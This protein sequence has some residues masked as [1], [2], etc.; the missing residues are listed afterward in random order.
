MISAGPPHFTRIVVLLCV[1][2]SLAAA[3]LRKP[4]DAEQWGLALAPRASGPEPIAVRLR[5]R[6][7]ADMPAAAT[8]QR[9]ALGFKF[10]GCHNSSRRNPIKWIISAARAHELGGRYARTSGTEAPPFFTEG[11]C[12]SIAAK[13]V[14]IMRQGR[15]RCQ[16]KS[17]RLR[18]RRSP[19]T[20]Q[21]F[22]ARSSGTRSSATS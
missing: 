9:G 1:S 15:M 22:S 3:A 5:I 7:E 4:H 18:G 17:C 20:F 19:N 11:G 6:F 10:S 14:A 12:K 8:G 2:E 16:E 21:N 13:H